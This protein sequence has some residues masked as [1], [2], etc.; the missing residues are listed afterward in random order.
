MAL[1]IS[2][3]G[4]VPA[5]RDSPVARGSFPADRSCELAN[6]VS[7]TTIWYDETQITEEDVEQERTQAPRCRGGPDAAFSTA[8]PP[9]LAKAELEEAFDMPGL[10]DEQVPERFFR[11]LRFER[12]A[13]VSER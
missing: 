3:S 11:P 6:N 4:Q 8:G 12:K 9:A 1:W 5:P 2:C 13:A 7:S 10:S